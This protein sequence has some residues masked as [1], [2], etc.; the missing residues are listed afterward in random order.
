MGLHTVSDMLSPEHEGQQE[1]LAPDDFVHP[2]LEH[3]N[4]QTVAEYGAWGVYGLVHGAGES[5]ISDFQMGRAVGEELR[6]DADTYGTEAMLTAMGHTPGSATDPYVK[7][8]EDRYTLIEL[9]RDPFEGGRP[10]HIA[11][12]EM[13]NS[14]QQGVTQ[15]LVISHT[16][17][18]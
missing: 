13:I 7:E 5:G 2:S 10:S 11:M 14:Y 3:N 17:N 6:Y 16:R 1:W 12:E 8:I 4:L 15:G 9:S 18:Y